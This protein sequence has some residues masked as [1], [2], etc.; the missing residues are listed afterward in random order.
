[1]STPRG[2]F[3]ALASSFTIVAASP[4]DLYAAVA[5]AP[6]ENRLSI[7]VQG[8][9]I[10]NFL[11]AL[12]EQARVN[13]ILGRGLEE[14]RVSVHLQDISMEDALSALEEAQG[15]RALAI[16]GMKVS[17]LTKSVTAP[18]VPARIAGGKELDRQ[19]IVRVKEGT[20]GSFLEVMSQQAK[21]SFVLGEEIGEEKFT[22]FLKGMTVREILEAVSA[23]YGLE[24]RRG[25][26]AGAYIVK[27]RS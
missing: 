19:L 2:T 15:L 14:E 8:V 18:K 1:M 23:V 16:P 12:S 9:R 6:L 20:L 3:F 10:G 24:F 26:R 27:R 7:H 13:F 11:D 4:P 25:K 21:L 17:L 5:S 22:A